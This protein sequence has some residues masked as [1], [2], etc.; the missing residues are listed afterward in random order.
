M[1]LTIDGEPARFARKRRPIGAMIA[2]IL[3]FL[4]LLTGAS[5]LEIVRVR[6]PAD[7]VG[8]WLAGKE[9]RV[10]STAEF[11]AKAAQLRQAERSAP[12]AG[13][14]LVRARHRARWD[15]ALLVGKSD[16]VIEPTSRGAADFPLAPWTPAIVAGAATGSL[17]TGATGAASL[18][19][20]PGA[21]RAISLDW[22]LR[23]RAVASARLLTLV[24]PAEPTTELEL[25]LPIAWS[26]RCRKGVLRGPI[27]SEKADLS[28]WRVDGELGGIDVR[29]YLDAAGEPVA[30]T[31]SWVSSS[32]ELDLRKPVG[33]GARL[34]NWKT[35][36][37][38]ELDPNNPTTLE[39]LVDPRL[40]LLSV[41]GSALRGY[42]ATRA[43][44]GTLVQA[45]LVGPVARI[46][47]SAGTVVPASG[48]WPMPT[49]RPLQAVWTGGTATV[50]LD[51][52]SRSVGYRET[53]GRE[54]HPAGDGSASGDRLV[55]EADSPD[56]V[57]ELILTP[58]RCESSCLVRGRVM[59]DSAPGRLECR[60]DYAVHRGLPTE[61]EIELGHG[62]APRQVS[63]PGLD[64][65]VSWHARQGPAG[66]TRVR[67][68]PPSPILSRK[69]FTILIEARSTEERRLGPLEL[70][71][72]RPLAPRVVDETWTAWALP[73]VLIEPVAARGVAWLDSETR[74][75]RDPDP[76][77][78]SREALAWRYTAAD[79]FLRIERGRV[80]RSPWATI[81]AFARIDPGARRMVIE[82]R[83]RIVAG[84]EPLRE[85]P[86]SI[87]QAAARLDNWR[88]E[89][90]ADPGPITI[91]ALTADESLERGL[92]K[93]ATALALGLLI[94]AR[95]HRTVAFHAEYPWDS[96]GLVPLLSPPDRFLTRGVIQVETPLGTRTRVESTGLER[97]D[98]SL[99]EPDSPTRIADWD[100]PDA[101]P[102]AATEPR[103][104]T[105]SLAYHGPGG[106]LEVATER[107]TPFGGAGVVR[108]ALLGTTIDEQGRS[109]NRLRL[110]ANLRDGVTLALKPP[111]DVVIVRVRRDGVP[112]AMNK[113]QI[114]FSLPIGPG[115]GG[116]STVIVIDYEVKAIGSLGRSPLRP[117]LPGLDIP[118]SA[119]VWEVA[120]PASWRVVETGPGLRSAETP[121]RST[122]GLD[123]G[124]LGWRELGRLVGIYPKVK[125]KPQ[126][127]ILKELDPSEPT[128]ADWLTRLDS[129]EVPVV[130]D[131]LALDSAGVGPR[132]R[133]D[134]G[135]VSAD[136]RD[137]AL[138]FLDRN[139]L[140]VARLESSLLI[141]TRDD[142]AELADPRV[143]ARG[144]M[145]A[146]VWGVD[147]TD[148][149]ENV[150]RWRGE[151]SPR[152][153]SAA[154]EDRADRARRPP[155]WSITRRIRAGWPDETCYLD[156]RNQPSSALGQWILAGLCLVAGGAALRI[157]SRARIALV[158]I[159]VA[160]LLLE[161]VSPTKYSDQP[162][163]ALL[164]V[165]VALADD[166][167]R[168]LGRRGGSRREP[169][170][171]R[172]SS[173]L[174]ANRASGGAVG[175]IAIAL[176]LGRFAPANGQERPGPAN[177]ILALF[178]YEGVLDPNRDP[179][180]VVLSLDD[181]TRLMAWSN[182]A[183]ARSSLLA[184]RARSIEHR[185]TRLG[186]GTCQVETELEID[187][188]GAEPAPW[189]FPTES[190]RDITASL[191]GK[192]IL[193]TIHQGGARGSVMIPPGSG[194]RLVIKRTATTHVH[195][196][197]QILD[198]PVNALPTASL[199][200]QVDPAES[201]LVDILS[202]GGVARDADSRIVCRLGPTERLQIHWYR[203]ADP[204]R[205]RPAIT[206]EGL[207]LWDVEPAG[208][209]LRA[210]F[211]VR[212]PAGLSTIAFKREPGLVLK[213][214]SVTG[215]T[216]AF[217][218]ENEARGE[219][220]LHV[221]PV[222]ASGSRIELE[223]YRPRDSTATPT[224]PTMPRR[225][226]RLE[227]AGWERYS[228]LLGARRPSDWTGR[229]EPQ[230]GAEVVADDIYVQ[231]WNRLPDDLLTFSGACRLGRE[232]SAILTTGPAPARILVKPTI[233]IAVEPGRLGLAVEADLTDL[234]GRPNVLA[235]QLPVGMRPVDVSGDGV[236]EWSIDAANRIRIAFNAPAIGG[237]RRIRLNGWIPVLLDPLKV[238]PERISARIPW[239][240]WDAVQDVGFLITTSSTVLELKG[241]PGLSRI[242]SESS[243]PTSAIP[244]TMRVTYRVDDPTRLGQF[245]WENPPPRA[246]VTIASQLAIHPDSAEWTAILRY[247]VIG[248]ALG[249]M[250]LRLPSVWSASAALHDPGGEFQI[251][252][253]TRGVSAFWTITPNRPIWGSRRLVLRSSIPLP[254]NRE[255]V[256]PEIAPLG[257][258]NVDVRVCVVNATRRAL[259]TD[260]SVG[261]QAIPGEGEFMDPE[262][263]SEGA[264]VGIFRVASEPWVLR[265]QS[266]QESTITREGRDAAAPATHA[267][268]AVVVSTDLGRLGRAFYETAPGGRV[269]SFK[270]PE[271]ATLLWASVDSSPAVPLRSAREIWSVPLDERKSARVGLLWRILP[272]RG[273]DRS[274]RIALGLPETVGG[275]TPAVIAVYAPAEVAI[276]LGAESLER[277]SL[278]RYDLARADALARSTRE[279]LPRLDRSSARDHEKL[280][281]MLIN[282]EMILREADRSVTLGPLFEPSPEGPRTIRESESVKLARG[283]WAE[284][285]R[286]LGLSA[287]LAAAR[288]YLGLTPQGTVQ[289]RI[290]APEQSPAER[291]PTLGRPTTLTGSLSGLDQ[292]AN[293]RP[294]SL[295]P[296]PIGFEPALMGLAWLLPPIVAMGMILI[297]SPGPS[298]RPLRGR[299]A[300]GLAL[301]VAGWSAGPF[302]L[303][304]VASWSA[305]AW[306]RARG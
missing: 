256:H 187:S 240:T 95:G 100:E 286:G 55:F 18:R 164:G 120:A 218:T 6:A 121:G 70:P 71:R 249:S 107:L 148:R 273:G 80:E 204:P 77:G 156:L 175:A 295:E 109:I 82:G 217:I 139:G 92:P 19:I 88:F 135:V 33:S 262:F 143:A 157:W 276:D 158:V 75:S 289:P 241:A 245:S 22:E 124:D 299:M 203:P 272:P 206:G 306:R 275:P 258:G 261:L 10:M 7:R 24:L 271:S 300:L 155:G 101:S 145:E 194:R 138:A 223:C 280:V 130:V 191:D 200:V 172:R 57:A 162:A 281:S 27:K 86:L 49:I 125:D 68:L 235:A 248:G 181:Y 283:E 196:D 239:I 208:D 244:A 89:D 45:T 8:E 108:Q 263:S 186:P 36:W 105:H 63:V 278:A 30:A 269:F 215:T 81:Q 153:G 225:P 28:A 99:L 226:P 214:V 260:S 190:S 212:E 87:N 298:Q 228:C 277:V 84:S 274:R 142:A 111:A 136:S 46:E 64:E 47:F 168:A 54:I 66:N 222:L 144:A 167:A 17:G 303:A 15:G 90:A 104:A 231:S 112:L 291:I 197:D 173:S 43:A 79:A 65:P 290:A 123:P 268:L 294:L 32:T 302:A 72:V 78:D 247:D 38:V 195:G 163:A 282:Q 213:R 110:V 230:A 205:P 178:P 266:P 114:G 199:V 103:V 129:G 98:P 122:P 284:T 91:Q 160:L 150:A 270:L 14:R 11:E 61:L 246:G 170:V 251:T 106:R 37:S 252:R 192:P 39:A 202:R 253:E 31:R 220:T 221:D 23:P 255:I 297:L 201:A 76:A 42:R 94:P 131:R 73:E 146:L 44:A 34:A 56:S 184:L 174:L 236:R 16:L 128:V 21:S 141:T 151:P 161:R 113:D 85:L 149:F 232:S 227:P 254:T 2:L 166:L 265:I 183:P 48:R 118:C 67:V 169:V 137:A 293:S 133:L 53:S 119:F 267:D 188:P 127:D 233:T 117:R 296:R 83:I 29:V 134:T 4:P 115:G 287:D 305:L 51:D 59:L 1:M 229:L 50:L 152:L 216:D 41:T 102:I 74:S 179:D 211:T 219:W 13:P 210:R 250:H 97:L 279:F 147:Q 159:G 154:T 301:A 9:L 96:V 259:T 193:P 62:W 304:A 132:T 209:R 234:S 238:V 93:G 285:T 264:R 237:R 52:A 171:G 224:E 182:P 177:A 60:L 243:L 69:E 198:L 207:V 25:E 5:G 40:E 12:I 292:P 35:T 242:T 288:S 20:E 58:P 185:A 140:A 116:R 189:E 176:A 126:V 180:R 3:G 257:R 165:L 26:P